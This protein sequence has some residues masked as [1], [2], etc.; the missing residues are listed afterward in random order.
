MRL[1]SYRKVVG[2]FRSRTWSD[3]AFC[4]EQEKCGCMRAGKGCGLDGVYFHMFKDL[5][6]RSL[7][8]VL[9]LNA[10]LLYHCDY[11]SRMRSG[12]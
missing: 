6:L 12:L 8:G 9:T 2:I 4:L 3:S 11:E 1:L 10:L 5:N 7:L